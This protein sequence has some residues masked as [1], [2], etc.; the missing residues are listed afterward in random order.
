MLRCTY[1]LVGK[2]G[3]TR[4]HLVFSVQW[5]G[6]E[7]ESKPIFLVGLGL[8]PTVGNKYDTINKTEE[9]RKMVTVK[10]TKVE[11]MKGLEEGAVLASLP[12]ELLQ[13]PSLASDSWAVQEVHLPR[14]LA[15]QPGSRLREILHL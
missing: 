9:G 4:A 8:Y 15:L 13:E 10:V 5:V 11:A 3:Q 7:G 14:A 6:E 12:V 1:G 2:A